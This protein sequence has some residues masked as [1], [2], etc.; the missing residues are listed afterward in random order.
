MQNENYFN[1][2]IISIPICKKRRQNSSISNTINQFFLL[3]KIIYLVLKTR[4]LKYRYST[5]RFFLLSIKYEKHNHFK[6]VEQFIK[7]KLNALKSV[8]LYLIWNSS[9]C[10]LSASRPFPCFQSDNSFPVLKN[11]ASTFVANKRI[12]DT[13]KIQGIKYSK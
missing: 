2:G 9:T 5:L 10:G 12:Q 4:R 1:T 3:S 8:L 13:D 6:T 11:N 7:F